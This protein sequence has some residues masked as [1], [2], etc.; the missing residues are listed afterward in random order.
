MASY[1]VRR[2]IGVI[3]VLFMVSLMV[4]ALTQLAP[5]DPVS[6]LVSDEASPEDRQ[7]IVEAWGLDRPAPVQY[8]SFLKNA[9]LGDFGSSF[10]YREPVM[11]LVLARLPASIELAV[12][13]TLLAVIIGIPLGVLSA[14]RPNSLLDNAGSLVGFFGV[15]MPNFWFGILLILVFAGVFNVLPSGGREPWGMDLPSIT[16]FL[17]IDALIQGR[18][19]VLWTALRH[20]ALPAIVLG[21][22]MTGIIMQLTRATVAEALREDYV[23]TARAK[24]LSERLVLWRHAF[25]N[26]LVAVVTIIGLEF[27]ALISGAIIVETVFSWPG[28]GMLLIQSI[29]FRDYPLIV[30]LVLIYTT[31]FV[32]VNVAI[33]ILYTII[34]PRIRMK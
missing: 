12:Y 11:D 32:L 27:G 26:A 13:A 33:D 17:T 1:L 23:M 4:F 21:T 19:D 25:R 22:S 16:G 7:K 31:L 6:M 29:T 14:A 9:V 34:D 5:G 3:P 24:G 30:G 2:L 18:F 10:R 8:L 15:S 20:L 28:I